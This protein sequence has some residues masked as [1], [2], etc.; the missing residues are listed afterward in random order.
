MTGTSL[1]RVVRRAF[2][3][4]GLEVQRPWGKENVKALIEDQCGWRD[5]CESGWR[6]MT[7]PDHEEPWK[8][9][10]WGLELWRTFEEI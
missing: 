1:Q 8:S 9:G 6:R 3:E 7:I 5:R 2:Q 10:Q 4:E